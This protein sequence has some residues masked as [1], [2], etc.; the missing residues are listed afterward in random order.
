MGVLSR[1]AGRLSGR[2]RV[3]GLILAL[4]A[5]DAALLTLLWDRPAA[6]SGAMLSPLLVAALFAGVEW[7]VIH[8]Q[9]RAEAS[10]FSLLELPLVLGVVFLPPRSLLI[11]A[12]VGVV[13]GL[14]VGRRQSPLKVVFN[15]ANVTLYA[16]IA[17]AVVQAL[18]GPDQL[19]QAMTKVD[20]LIVLA[21]VATG[22]VVNMSVIM[23]AIG[24][25]EGPPPAAKMAELVGFG[26]G[27]SAANGAV[28]LVA[29]LLLPVDPFSLALLA[30]PAVVLFAAARVF[31]AE[32]SQR[33]RMEFLYRSTH[34]LDRDDPGHGVGSLLDEAREMFRAE[35]G[36]LV[37]V[38]ADEE[39]GGLPARIVRSTE[40]ERTEDRTGELPTEL[41]REAAATLD[42]AQ[43]VEHDALG[44]LSAVVRAVGGRTAM[45][46]RLATDD[47][48]LGLL[49]V[50]DRL[51]TVASFQ[52][53]DL[54]VLDALA[55]QSAVQLRSGH[56]AQAVVE[57]RALER[58]LAH[59]ATHDTLTGLANRTLFARRLDEAAGGDEPFWVLYLDLDDFKEVNDTHGHAAGDEVL[60]EAARRLRA[61]LRPID[62]VARLGG[63]E[64][65]V[66]LSNHP[67]PNDVAERIVSVVSAPIELETGQIANIGCSVGVAEGEP[68]AD[69]QD[70]MEAAD[71][72]MYR[73]KA[74]TKAAQGSH[75]PRPSG[76][77]R[78]AT[79]TIP[80]EQLEVHYQPM[81][82]LASG[83]V[84]GVEALVRWRC[85]E[86]GLLLPH[87]FLA[88]AET[89][90]SIVPL[91]RW[92]LR[93]AWNDIER[94][95]RDLL[96][97]VNLSAHHLG[98]PDLAD[99]LAHEIL[100]GRSAEGRLGLELTERAIRV[101]ANRG[102]VHL[103]AIRR[104]GVT[105]IL[106]DFGTGVSS[107]GYLQAAPVEMVKLAPPLFTGGPRR[108]M[109]A[110]VTSL[111]QALGRRVVA[112]GLE[113]PDDAEAARA[114][115]CD[116][117]QGFLFARP[118]TLDD[119]RLL[120]GAP[121]AADSTVSA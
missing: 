3:V 62:V 38:E 80:E 87:H 97:S 35:V 29:A 10:S 33:E 94:L 84:A 104:L 106:G 101:D 69:P 65:A 4:L 71:Q 45:V 107:I 60:V 63:D 86:R 25:T 111:I 15:A 52:R 119:L 56:L 46:A 26:V 6:F 11:A 30:V 61:Q 66:L 39:H 21:A 57:L 13:I 74:A 43:L 17:V 28:S 34:Q 18:I 114:A 99:F 90:G 1:V 64:F 109:S 12:F 95:G 88:N 67:D 98:S 89:D 44:P 53:D 92:V 37:L 93:R 40:P 27:V 110:A 51:G 112:Q 120:L 75:P 36:A 50:A 70:L 55:R 115:G 76:P 59:A 54:L 83:E 42:Q 14:A 22:S 8:I 102:H 91:D 23:T 20:W 72:A 19:G 68:G 79:S 113:H 2:S 49:V 117:A 105:P 7:R 118:M 16:A 58:E 47:R 78:P 31:A 48:D 121:S 41:V 5:V 116:W 85:P 24:L 100:D 96:V 81:V 9:L 108:A 77:E 73:A 103:D 32:Q 82:A